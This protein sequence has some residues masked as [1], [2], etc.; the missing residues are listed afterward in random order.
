MRRAL[1]LLL[2]AGVP[3][4]AEALSKERLKQTPQ[5]VFEAMRAV[6][7][8]DKARGVHARY[9]FEISGPRGG[10]WWITVDDGKY[11]MGR[12]RRENPDLTLLAS[13]NDWVALSNDQLSGVWATLT[14]RLKIRGSQALARKLD[15]MFP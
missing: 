12:G 15:E 1:L 6:F 5:D 8:P 3:L 2:V 14:G 4:C 7:Q 10:E 9:Q 11:K 13:D